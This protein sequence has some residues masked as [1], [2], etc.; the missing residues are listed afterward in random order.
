[1]ETKIDDK[2]ELLR[3]FLAALAYRTQKALRDAP[4]DF[5]SFCAVDGARTPTHL[6][7]SRSPTSIR[8]GS[9]PISLNRQVRMQSGPRRRLIGFRLRKVDYPATHRRGSRL[10]F[11]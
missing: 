5:G 6:K 7:I 10:S 3:H 11:Q 8:N 9:G 2:R 1:M 4:D